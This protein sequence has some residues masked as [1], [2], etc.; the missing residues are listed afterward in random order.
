MT[1]DEIIQTATEVWGYAAWKGAPL[2]RLKK[3]TE[4]IE[5]NYRDKVLKVCD[6]YEFNVNGL[7]RRI[8][9]I[10]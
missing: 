3:F 1:Q 10:K 4:M 5:S 9:K 2:D 6:E 8:K 7:V